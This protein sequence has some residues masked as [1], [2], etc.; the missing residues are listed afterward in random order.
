MLDFRFQIYYK[1]GLRPGFMGLL[2]KPAWSLLYWRELVARA[3]K[4]V[5]T[6]S[7][8]AVFMLRCAPR[9]WKFV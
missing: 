8:R 3:E 1:D 9:A 5:V 2:R 4:Q 7:P 6:A